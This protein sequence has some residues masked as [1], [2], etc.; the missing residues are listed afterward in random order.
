MA[1]RYFFFNL[2][3]SVQ[4]L[5]SNVGTTLE[6]WYKVIKGSSGQVKA[7]QCHAQHY[8]ALQGSFYRIIDIIAVRC[9]L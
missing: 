9:P 2:E 3:P 7:D 5:G 6:V 8:T 4:I 1:F